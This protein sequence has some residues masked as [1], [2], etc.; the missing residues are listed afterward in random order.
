MV[1]EDAL[2][3]E[4]EPYDSGMLAVSDGHALY[5]E[6]CGNPGGRPIVFLHGGP[7][8]GCKP[9]HRRYYDP[10]IWRIVLFD[11]RGCGRSAPHGVIDNNTT[12]H[13]VDDIEVL[14]QKLGIE[15]WVISGGSWGSFLS[16]AYA[17]SHPERCEALLIRGI[18]LGRAIERDWWWG[19]TRWLF[20][21]EWER[22]RD[23]LPVDERDDLLTGYAKRLFDPDP[24]VHL[25]AAKAFATYNAS[26]LLFRYDA[27]FVAQ[28][29]QADKA[30]PVARLFTNYCRNDFFVEDGQLLA[31]I[32]RIRHLPAIIVQGRYDVITPARS[33][34]DLAR[35]W[36]EAEFE[37]VTDANHSIEEPAMAAALVAAQARLAKRLEVGW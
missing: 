21:A 6:Q 7:G 24:A 37:I 25:P 4:L 17:E 23:A 18:F 2:F 35:A 10:S 11:Q 3:P 13:L 16:L 20:P 22:F 31:D 33:A 36:P 12:Q 32:G 14:R 27:E 34:W 9:R 15:R 5:Y 1:L 26:T 19:G 28:S 8:G 30:L 29:S